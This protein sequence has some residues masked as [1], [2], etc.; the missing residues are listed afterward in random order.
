MGYFITLPDLG[1]LP[2]F[3]SGLRPYWLLQAQA[4]AAKKGIAEQYGKWVDASQRLQ[5][6]CLKTNFEAARRSRL[7]G[8]SHW[9][10][11]D[12]PNCAEGVVDMF[13]RP[14]A[15]ERSRV[16]EIQRADRLAAGYAAAHL[17]RRRNRPRHAAGLAVRGQTH[18]RR[19]TPLGAARGKEVVTAGAREN[20]R[21]TAEGVQELAQVTLALPRRPARK[22]SHSPW[23]SSMKT[24]GLPTSGASGSSPMILSTTA[25]R[26]LGVSATAGLPERYPWARQLDSAPQIGQCELLV[27]SQFDA[28]TVEYLQQGGRVLLLAPDK[29]FPTVPSRFPPGWLGSRTE[30]WPFGYPSSKGPSGAVR[31]GG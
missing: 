6:V 1:Q 27:T 12:Y 23:T 17:S 31:H 19:C 21:V 22:S 28:G 24:E 15:L 20:V 3:R 18:Y 29:A 11:Q 2:L 14:K 13:F 5:A 26:K 9:L 4:L 7:S 25:P 16:P 10:F 30:G 8:Y